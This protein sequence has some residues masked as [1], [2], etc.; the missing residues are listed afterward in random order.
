M[1][2]W[3]GV[4]S[5]AAVGGEEGRVATDPKSVSRYYFELCNESLSRE[6][7]HG[8]TRYAY[9]SKV[10]ATPTGKIDNMIT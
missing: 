7:S 6:R 8:I 5:S 4:L 3:S 2:R 10:G 1:I 9:T